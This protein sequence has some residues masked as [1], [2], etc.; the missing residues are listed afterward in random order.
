MPHNV[1]TS[2]CTR[3]EIYIHIPPILDQRVRKGKGIVTLLTT[4]EGLS[5]D[6][7]KDNVIKHEV[8]VQ[9]YTRLEN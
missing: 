7:G 2:P 9:K 1:R 8:K 5:Q 6:L 3:N 4:E